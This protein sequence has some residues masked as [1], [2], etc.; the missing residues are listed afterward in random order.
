MLMVSHLLYS[1]E[2]KSSENVREGDKDVMVETLHQQGTDVAASAFKV[3]WIT[4]RVKR[5][6]RDR[7]REEK[8]YDKLNKIFKRSDF[9][10]RC[11]FHLLFS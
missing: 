1:V 7:K 6:K 3:S 4:I 5:A 11:A 8:I 10:T 2:R 9:M